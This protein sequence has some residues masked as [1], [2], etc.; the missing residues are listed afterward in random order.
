MSSD[1]LQA[2]E[3]ESYLTVF[4][5]QLLIYTKCICPEAL[6]RFTCHNSSFACWPR[7]NSL[8][9]PDCHIW[10]TTGVVEETQSF[11]ISTEKRVQKMKNKTA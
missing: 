9:S 2:S 1:V 11:V 7:K 6:D 5:F 10:V 3:E 8:P 4:F